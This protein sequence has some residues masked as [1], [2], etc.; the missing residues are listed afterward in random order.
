VKAFAES[1]N[2]EWGITLTR[3]EQWGPSRRF[4]LVVVNSNHAGSGAWDSIFMY[5]CQNGVYVS[6]FS[7][8]YLYGVTVEIGERSDFW[9][10]AGLW[11]PNDPACCPSR[12]RR[13]HHVW[14]RRQQRFVIVES[15]VRPVK[16]LR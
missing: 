1:P 16:T 4:L 14:N 13:R 8:R 9:I 12:E 2:R 3:A 11:K 15:A 7:D 5:V 6:V 10:T